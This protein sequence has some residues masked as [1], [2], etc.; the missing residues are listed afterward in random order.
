LSLSTF[1]IRFLYIP[2]SDGIQAAVDHL[3][4]DREP[5]LLPEEDAPLADFEREDL[6]E[7]PD[8]EPELDFLAEE[9]LDRL[10]DDRLDPLLDEDDLEP[11]LFDDDDRELLPP[12]LE[13]EERELLLLEE[14][15]RP[16]EEEPFDEELFE[17]E[18]F[19]LDDPEDLLFP[20]PLADFPLEDLDEPEDFDEPL[21][22]DDP[23]RPPLELFDED[24][25][26]EFE[27][28]LRPPPDVPACAP[29]A[30]AD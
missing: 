13:D 19:L 27:P 4:R 23:E 6:E 10:P 28:P 11:P 16:F 9:P 8:L 14:D 26:P 12:L 5:E 29:P 15:E 21:F 30:S 7:L 2:S 3:P 1:S 22:E 18:D 20:P 17:P 24:D 25:L